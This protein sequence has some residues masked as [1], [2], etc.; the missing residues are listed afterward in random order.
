M[1]NPPPPRMPAPP[2]KQ[3]AAWRLKVGQAIPWLLAT[4][5]A[6]LLIQVFL[7][8][9]GLLGADENLATHELFAN[10]AI[11]LL[12]LLI[13]VVGFVGADLRVGIA[14]IVLTALLE[15]QYALIDAED[16]NVRGLH[17]VNGVAML[18]V[19]FTLLLRRLPWVAR[20]APAPKA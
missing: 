1:A 4:T 3:T 11:R 10:A 12:F 14:G 7:A 15:L 17:A 13:L 20:P 18:L 8:A 2:K 19:A 9:S 6:A 5:V 16:G